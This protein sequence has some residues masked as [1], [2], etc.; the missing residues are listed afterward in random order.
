M[1]RYVILAHDWP[2]PHFDFLLEDGTHLHG[3]RLEA[4]PQPGEAIPATVL[5]R[6]RL[7]Y[8]NYE[9]PLTGNRGSVKRVD[10]GVFEWTDQSPESIRVKLQGD[11]FQGPAEWRPDCSTWH[12]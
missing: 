1:P 9:G 2:Y 11:V 4:F 3:W 12:F 10:R 6:H 8:L 7:I 5:P